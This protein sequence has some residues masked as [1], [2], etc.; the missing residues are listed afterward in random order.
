MPPLFLIINN[1]M[2]LN[3]DIQNPNYLNTQTFQF[4]I[5]KCPSMASFVQTVTLPPIS[6]GEVIAATPFVDRK[7][8]GD[9]IIYSALTVSFALDEDMLTWLE[10]YDWIRGVGFPQSYSEYRNFPQRG[11]K[12]V[13]D[14]VY[15]DGKLLIYN[16]QSKPMYEVT[17]IN[18]FPL[19][20]GDIPFSPTEAS[21]EVITTTAAFQFTDYTIKKL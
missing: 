21:D 5:P 3:T 1:S 16:N 6:F 2:R 10:V 9:K 18:M 12:L 11:V 4:N 13:G 20:L 17:F 14:E 8:A 15:C 7:E 19:A